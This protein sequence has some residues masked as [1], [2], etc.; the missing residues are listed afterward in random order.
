MQVVDKEPSNSPAPFC[1]AYSCAVMVVL[2]SI[3]EIWIK[4]VTATE[5]VF[6]KP[7][8]LTYVPGPHS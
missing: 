4:V 2:E 1:L 7:H 6:H 3:S 5:L 8:F